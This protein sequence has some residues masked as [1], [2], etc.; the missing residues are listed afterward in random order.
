ME[1]IPD[2]TSPM[3]KKA[4][5]ALEAAVAK[6]VKDHRRRDAPLAIWRD[7]KAMW[8]MPPPADSAREESGNYPSKGD[9]VRLRSEE[10]AK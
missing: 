5:A 9:N 4:L 8:E 6:V 10:D 7:G 1:L 3:A 2:I